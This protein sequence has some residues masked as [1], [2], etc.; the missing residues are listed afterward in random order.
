MIIISLGSPHVRPTGVHYT[1]GEPNEIELTPHWGGI[2]RP[3]TRTRAVAHA[4]PV[5]V[6]DCRSITH[7][8][9]SIRF[10]LAR[11]TYDASHPHGAYVGRAKRNHHEE[12]HPPEKHGKLFSKTTC[13]EPNEIIMKKNTHSKHM[14]TALFKTPYPVPQ[15]HSTGPPG[16]WLQLAPTRAKDR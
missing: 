7:G 11:R 4:A 10:R 3:T 2:E 9:G 12:K 6:T 14:A 16:R 5:P 1:R 13:G 15:A 8:W